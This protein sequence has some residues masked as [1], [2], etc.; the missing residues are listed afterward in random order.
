MISL[1]E[2]FGIF[3]GRE[4]IDSLLS[5]K[6]ALRQA[7]VSYALVFLVVSIL[8]GF[9]AF[10]YRLGSGI[11]AGQEAVSLL[12]DLVILLAVM[13]FAIPMGLILSL[14]FSYVWGALHFFIANFYSKSYDI[15][16]FNSYAL[17]VFASVQLVE[18]LVFLIP[19]IGWLAVPV[20]RLYGS[21]LLFKTVRQYFSLSDAQA[22]I[23]VL[24]PLN[25]A[26]LAVLLL[27]FLAGTIIVG[28]Q[29][30]A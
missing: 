22:A 28:P 1:R 21:V 6:L 2:L 29:F 18:G 25:L 10:L 11:L 30:L 9:E 16:N 19:V 3:T 23:V 14:F 17:P 7:V 13:A 26:M 20:I 8:I 15:N 27:A 12:I 5:K 4:S 24:I